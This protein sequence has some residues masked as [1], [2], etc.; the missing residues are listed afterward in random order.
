MFQLPGSYEWKENYP[1][2]VWQQIP[3][4]V[5]TLY[6][7]SHRSNHWCTKSPHWVHACVSVCMS[8]CVCVCVCVTYILYY[9]YMLLLLR[10]RLPLYS[11][12]PLPSVLPDICQLRYLPCYTPT[13]SSALFH[14][15]TVEPS[16][17]PC[18]TSQDLAAPGREQW[19]HRSIRH[20]RLLTNERFFVARAAEEQAV[21]SH[22]R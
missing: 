4:I 19:H 14:F 18:Y 21:G 8:V 10:S 13:P 9:F 7:N 6:Y 2:R 11:P 1:W 3:L 15:H 5:K 12:V 16:C 20:L 22:Y 17:P